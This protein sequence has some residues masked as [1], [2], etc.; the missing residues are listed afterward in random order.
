MRRLD[1][2]S[3]HATPVLEQVLMAF[4]LLLAGT[5]LF[6][7]VLDK[8]GDVML[9]LIAPLITFVAVAPLFAGGRPHH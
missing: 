9:A 2:S 4:A 1:L 7:I 6:C 3:H 5:I 8:T